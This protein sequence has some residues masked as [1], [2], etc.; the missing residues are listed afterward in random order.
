MYL[1]YNSRHREAAAIKAAVAESEETISCVDIAGQDEF[2]RQRTAEQILGE[3]L[4]LGSHP[5]SQRRAA[6]TH[7]TKILVDCPCW[8]CTPDGI[9]GPVQT[10]PESG[11]TDLGLL[12]REAAYHHRLHR[13]NVRELPSALESLTLRASAD[14]EDMCVRAAAL[15]ELHGAAVLANFLGPAHAMELADTDF[16]SPLPACPGPGGVQSPGT[17]RGDW[18]VLPN[19]E[20]TEFLSKLD[21]FIS[22]LRPLTGGKM[23]TCEFRTWPMVTVYEPGSRYTWH[24]DNGKGR[25]GRLLTCI[26]YLNRDWDL[27]SGGELRLLKQDNE[28]HQVLAEVPP[29]LD[30]LVLFWSESVPHEVLPPWVR[31]RH[32]LSVWYLC[33][34]RGLEHFSAGN[35]EAAFGQSVPS[36]VEKIRATL[37]ALGGEATATKEILDQLS[38]LHPPEPQPWCT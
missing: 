38:S 37:G 36:A 16:G 2:H 29:A 34:C 1:V 25:N 33:P 22:G 17:G 9:A 3:S 28:M 18:A 4:R 5:N 31:L 32:A 6:S 35:A 30:T 8:F 20:P 7:L 12:L 21:A 11:G 23:D 19:E 27:E 13:S 10:S 15:L 14:L 26:Y 24:L